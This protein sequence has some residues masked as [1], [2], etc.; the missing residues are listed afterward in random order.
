[1]PGG[2]RCQLTFLDQQDIFAALFGE[3]ICKADAH[4]AA[5]ND[6]NL[7]VCIDRNLPPFLF[8]VS[9]AG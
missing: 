1:M 2:T 5:A 9:P 6:N 8:M 7:C 4:N 3:V